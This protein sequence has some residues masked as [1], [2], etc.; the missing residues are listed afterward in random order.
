MSPPLTALRAVLTVRA[1][2]QWMSTQTR[3]RLGHTSCTRSEMEG[4]AHGRLSR[5][6]VLR[7][8]PR[9]PE[10]DETPAYTGASGIPLPGFEVHRALFEFGSTELDLACRCGIPLMPVTAG[11][12]WET[13]HAGAVRLSVVY[14]QASV[15]CSSHHRLLCDP[16]SPVGPRTGS[17]SAPFRAKQARGSRRRWR[18][19]FVVAVAK[20]G[21]VRRV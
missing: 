13:L 3:Y 14:H 4:A 1:W 18:L 15:P 7:S 8:V 11:R 2:R 12:R 21:A 20:R 16:R 17:N 6:T 19:L 10:N 5:V 9:D